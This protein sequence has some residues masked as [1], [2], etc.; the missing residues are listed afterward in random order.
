MPATVGGKLWFN[1]DVD[2]NGDGT[3]EWHWSTYEGHFFLGP[4]AGGSIRLDCQAPLSVDAAQSTVSVTMPA[5]CIGSPAAVSVRT[6]MRAPASPEALDVAPDTGWSP[7][8][9]LGVTYPWPAVPVPA[10][11]PAPTAPA[12]APTPVVPAPVPATSATPA[13]ATPAGPATAAAPAPSP[14]STPV[15]VPSVA[16]PS[17]TA[18][19]ARPVLTLARTAT[20]VRADFAPRFA[21]STVVLQLRAGKAW[22]Q[23]AKARLNAKGDAQLRLSAATRAKA[24]KGAVLRVVL[25]RTAYPVK[26]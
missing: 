20:T 11:A 9:L 21:R 22:K 12:V 10:P 3:A 6:A 19:P 4:V 7:R 1:G 18:V 25:G 26:R 16:A 23:V 13:P 24:R 17:H 2:T 8:A 14:A 5:S 15:A